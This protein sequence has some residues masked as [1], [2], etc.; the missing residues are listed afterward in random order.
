MNKQFV[1]TAELDK[2][3]WHYF[4]GKY[5]LRNEHGETVIL[6]LKKSQAKFL[7]RVFIRLGFNFIGCLEHIHESD[8]PKEDIR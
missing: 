5:E 7:E 8:L 4:S 3:K 1:A 2:G 6:F